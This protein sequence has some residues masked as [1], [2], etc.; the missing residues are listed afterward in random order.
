MSNWDGVLKTPGQVQSLTIGS[1]TLS[2]ADAVGGAGCSVITLTN[3]SS[4]ENADFSRA[5]N[6]IEP[7]TFGPSGTI[8]TGNPEVDGN[9]GPAANSLYVEGTTEWWRGFPTAESYFYAE[10]GRFLNPFQ[11]ALEDGSSMITG[12]VGNDNGTQQPSGNYPCI[13]VGGAAGT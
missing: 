1:F 10:P 11:A 4:S 7:T 3:N 5:M 6:A 13:N 12:L 8:H 2:D 9:N